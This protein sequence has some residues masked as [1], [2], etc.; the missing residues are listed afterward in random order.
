MKDAPLRAI[1][2]LTVIGALL[3]L[4]AAAIAT[5]EILHA[6]RSSRP[7]RAGTAARQAGADSL[8]LA[9]PRVDNH[10]AAEQ[11]DAA[12]EAQGGTRTAS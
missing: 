5:Y 7:A 4:G 2:T 9:W 8:P 10:R 6:V 12:D 1:R 11:R 3:V